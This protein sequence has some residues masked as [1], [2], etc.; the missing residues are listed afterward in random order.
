MISAVNQF[1]NKNEVGKT[2]YSIMAYK[3]E[4]ETKTNNILKFIVG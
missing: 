2:S 4:W 3:P 1:K